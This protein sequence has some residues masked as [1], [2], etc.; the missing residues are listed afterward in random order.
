M[1]T[2]ARSTTDGSP[3]NEAR[4]YARAQ[5][6]HRPRRERSVWPVRAWDGCLRAQQPRVLCAHLNGQW[7]Q[8]GP[9]RRDQLRIVDAHYDLD[10]L[11]PGPLLVDVDDANT[12]FGPR[13]GQ[14]APSTDGHRVVDGVVTGA[15]AAVIAAEPEWDQ[16]TR[17][18]VA[19]H[20][21]MAISQLAG[22][23][24]S[25]DVLYHP[26]LEHGTCLRGNAL[27]SWEYTPGL[28]PSSSVQASTLYI[29]LIPEARRALHRLDK[30]THRSA[31][32]DALAMGTITAGDAARLASLDEWWQR[33]RRPARSPTPGRRELDAHRPGT[34]NAHEFSRGW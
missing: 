2:V 31:V 22:G 17:Q 33:P 4:A 9:A 13:P 34:S 32:D 24:P 8:L 23:V 12:I 29:D 7:W 21:A 25:F 3:G 11:L 26:S 16:T 6:D 14:R 20:H 15:P 30:F 19:A 28:E 5:F 27:V 10:H 1:R 18:Q